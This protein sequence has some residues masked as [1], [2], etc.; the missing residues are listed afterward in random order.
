MYKYKDNTAHLYHNV[1]IISYIHFIYQL[2]LCKLVFSS[3]KPVW[4]C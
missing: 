2:R 1:Y 4:C 3:R